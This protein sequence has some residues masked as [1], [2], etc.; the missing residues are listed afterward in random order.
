[1]MMELMLMGI[2]LS[3]DVES[4]LNTQRN[5]GRVELE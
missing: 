2:H 3:R 1:M 5:F 4:E